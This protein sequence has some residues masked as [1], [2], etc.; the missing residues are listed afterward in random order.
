LRRQI[1]KDFRDA[2]IE[3]PTHAIESVSL[4]TNRRLLLRGDYVAVW[5]REVAHEDC[6]QGR[7]ALLPIK[8]PSAIGAV[9]ITTRA[10]TRLPP[11]AKALIEAIHECSGEP[12]GLDSGT[13]MSKKTV[14]RFG[15]VRH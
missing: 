14:A 9:G 10:D 6:E 3:P 1:D 5:P 11:A 12:F 7:L 13:K 8:L 15:A 4:L 2:G